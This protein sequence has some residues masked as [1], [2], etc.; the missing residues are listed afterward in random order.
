MCPD[1]CNLCTRFVPSSWLTRACSRR[2]GLGVRR[3]A[4]RS[5]LRPEPQLMRTVRRTHAKNRV[6]A[7][8]SK[9][10]RVQWRTKKRWR[11]T[12]G[13]SHSCSRKKSPIRILAWI[14]RTKRWVPFIVTQRTE[15][16]GL[17][18]SLRRGVLSKRRR[19]NLE[20]FFWVAG[21]ILMAATNDGG[22]ARSVNK[23]R[24]P[25]PPEGWRLTRGW[26]GRSAPATSS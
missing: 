9:F 19:S 21:S 17:T 26:S 14:S 3:C 8:F 10:R 24:R 22:V 18:S 16:V 20:L 5:S 6:N 7:L 2:P 23:W 11:S 13:S 1:T 12:R 4:S 15:S 25:S